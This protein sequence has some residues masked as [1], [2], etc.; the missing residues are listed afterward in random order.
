MLGLPLA[1]AVITACGGGDPAQPSAR[2]QIDRVLKRVEPPLERLSDELDAI[3]PAERNSLVALRSMARDAS[4]AVQDA[5]DELETVQANTAA[6][7]S[8]LRDADTAL[9]SIDDLAEEIG[10][11]P[12]ST[13]RIERAGADTE[14]ALGSFG[15]GALPQLSIEALVARLRSERRPPPPNNSESTGSEAIPVSDGDLTFRNWSGPAFQAKVPTGSG[16]STPA[17]TE[18]TPGE[19][20]RTS[21]R[22]P[23]GQFLIIDYTPFESAKFGGSYETMRTVGQTAF[24]SATEYVFQGGTLPECQRAR[25]IDFLINDP[26][27]GRGFGVLAGGPDFA[28]SRTVAQ[29]VMESVTPAN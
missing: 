14:R 4:E 20:F 21:V 1:T 10:R 13:A 8:M 23:N 9:E 7:R 18:P 5:R 27:G 24:G 3:D 2:S 26:A 19:L 28:L 11:D 15:V 16:W 25:C 17:T 29:T 12:A 6:E 22:G